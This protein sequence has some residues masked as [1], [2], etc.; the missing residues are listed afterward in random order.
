MAFAPWVVQ[1]APTGGGIVQ[2][3][4]H[5]VFFTVV[6]ITVT[7]LMV[8]LTGVIVLLVTDADTPEAHA[9]PPALDETPL[10]E[11]KAA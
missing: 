6:S 2:D 11:S 3:V 10:L 5:S 1:I 9:A 8:G 7:L 4:V